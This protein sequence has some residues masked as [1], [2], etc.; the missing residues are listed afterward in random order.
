MTPNAIS[1][2]MVV[3]DLRSL[4]FYLLGYISSVGVV[5]LLFTSLDQ[6]VHLTDWMHS[7]KAALVGRVTLSIV[8]GSL[9]WAALLLAPSLLW[10][11]ISLFLI[12]SLG[13]VT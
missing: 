11:P 5:L 9:S 2:A 13:A 6:T 8:L 10:I 12:I 3:A 7:A 1:A 4:L